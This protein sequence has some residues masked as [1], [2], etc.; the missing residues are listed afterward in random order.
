LEARGVTAAILLLA[1]TPT[2]SFVQGAPT[3]AAEAEPAVPGW[4][5]KVDELFE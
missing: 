3:F 2:R 1:A 4:R 5:M